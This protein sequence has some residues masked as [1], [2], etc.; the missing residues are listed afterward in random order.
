MDSQPKKN[1]TIKHIRIPDQIHDA[2]EKCKEKEGFH[3]NTN[4]I[5]EL[6]RRSLKEG[7]YL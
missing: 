3:T 5:I 1:S 6:L 7:G 4:A 2:I